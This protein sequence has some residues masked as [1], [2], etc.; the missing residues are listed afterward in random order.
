VNPA[1]YFVS[2][3]PSCSVWVLLRHRAAAVTWPLPRSFD[4][5]SEAGNIIRLAGTIGGLGDIAEASSKSEFANTAIFTQGHR[6]L[7]SEVSRQHA[8]PRPAPLRRG[9]VVRAAATVAGAAGRRL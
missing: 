8:V 3:P 4:R 5:R 7:A 2:A 9:E 1:V 6:G